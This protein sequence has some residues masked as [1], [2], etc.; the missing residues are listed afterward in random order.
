ML[1]VNAQGFGVAQDI[2]ALEGDRVRVVLSIRNNRDAP[3]DVLV[4]EPGE[5]PPVWEFIPEQSFRRVRF[6]T[7]RA[8]LSAIAVDVCPQ[9]EPTRRLRFA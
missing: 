2:V 3:A 1:D 8:M 4:Y 7:R 6:E 5:Q 9:G